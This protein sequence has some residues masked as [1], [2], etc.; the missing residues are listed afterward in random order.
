MK[1]LRFY[2]LCKIETFVSTGKFPQKKIKNIR[3]FDIFYCHNMEVT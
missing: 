3:E 1:F 2:V